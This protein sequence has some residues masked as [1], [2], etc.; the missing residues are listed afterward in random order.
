[1]TTISGYATIR[2]IRESDS[3][4]TVNIQSKEVLAR[5]LATENISVEHRNV[6]T[7]SFDVKSRNL[8]LPLW[9]DMQ[10]FTYDHLV[11]MKLACFIY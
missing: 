3:Q 10:N 8:V 1:M 6:G 5:L 11:R 9:D 7:A 4:M 2:V